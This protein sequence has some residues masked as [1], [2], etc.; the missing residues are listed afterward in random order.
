MFKVKITVTGFGKDDKYP[1]HM[2]YKIGD[3]II[4]DGETIT[5]RICPSMVTNFAQ[6][7]RALQ[8][9]GGRHKEGEIP[10]SYYPF[11]HSPASLYYPAYKKYDG[12]GFRPTLER[13]D[14]GYKFVSDETLFDT[15]PGGRYIIGKG[16]EKQTITMQCN[17]SHT[18]V[19]FKAEAFDLADKGDSLPYYRRAMT[20]LGKILKKQGIAID[21]ILNEYTKDEINNIYPSLGQKMVA[22]LVGELELLDYVD[23]KGGSVTATENGREKLASFV[24]GLTVEEKK[25]LK[26]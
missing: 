12:I 4:F 24:K 14:E 16:K 8:A 1:C 6:A 9:S 23:V 2:H 21:K 7:F 17:D 10:A 20:I 22:V 11:W 3:E 26:V 19:R 5:G 15:P 18:Y 25:A 13:P